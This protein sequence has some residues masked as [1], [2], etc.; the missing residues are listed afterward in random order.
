[1]SDLRKAQQLF[2]AALADVAQTEGALPLFAG[3][4]AQVR[5]RIA[6]YRGNVS[7]NALHALAG[8]YP[9]VCKLLGDEFFEGLA[10][11][12][13]RTHP[14]TSGDLNEFGALFAD[15]TA[16][17]PHTQS[18]PYLADVARMEWCAH[19]AYYA[20]DHPEFDPRSLAR[21]APEDYPALRLCL[22]A[23]VSLIASMHPL[24]QMWRVHQADYDGDMDVDF[25][26]GGENV[27]IFRTA[28]R[29]S[30]AQVTDGEMAFLAAGLR[31]QTIGT[32]LE[33][34]LACDSRFALGTS[35]QCWVAAGI[36]V[37]L[38]RADTRA[39]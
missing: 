2:G 28:Y 23:A 34:A 27:V 22:H 33:S 37:E 21:L 11:A 13:V 26:H 20:A 3:T 29:V 6:I 39:G 25:T 16:E 24:Y 8:A 15:F 35:L 4:A 17:F 31:R 19:R 9:I 32:A 36:I 18:L 38:D 30:V 10:R 12:Y 14:S 5:D 1:M 7:G